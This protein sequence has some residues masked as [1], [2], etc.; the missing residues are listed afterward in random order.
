MYSMTARRAPAR[1]GRGARTDVGA[2]GAA[3]GQDEPQRPQI[4]P[5]SQKY[6]ET[7]E[8]NGEHSAAKCHAGVVL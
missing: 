2:V 5:R 7:G 8:L 6:G 1:V 4:N 3:N